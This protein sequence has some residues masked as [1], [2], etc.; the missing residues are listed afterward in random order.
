MKRLSIRITDKL[1]QDIDDI[2]PLTPFRNR[3]D[4]VRHYLIRIIEKY[5]TG[6]KVIP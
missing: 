3:S 1:M 5:K 2:I 6:Q 4:L